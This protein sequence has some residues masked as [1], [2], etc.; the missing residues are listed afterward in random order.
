[1]FCFVVRCRQNA[2]NDYS[3]KKLSDDNLGD[4]VLCIRWSIIYE[5]IVHLTQL[6]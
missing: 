3:N 2:I 5:S 6:S 4:V 1:M